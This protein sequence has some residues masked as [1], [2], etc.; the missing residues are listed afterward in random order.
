MGVYSQGIEKSDARIQ[1][2]YGVCVEKLRFPLR[3]G[4]IV[5]GA[6]AFAREHLLLP[7]EGTVLSIISILFQ[8]PRVK[9]SFTPRLI[10]SLTRAVKFNAKS[11]GS[12]V[13]HRQRRFNSRLSCA[14]PDV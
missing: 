11:I 13:A 3:A 7:E 9:R 1:K 5:L 2:Q 12:M 14:S 10:P 6:S 8:F 4:A